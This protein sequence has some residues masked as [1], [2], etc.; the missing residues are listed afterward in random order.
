M[1]RNYS[2]LFRL[3]GVLLA[4]GSLAAVRS[5]PP[6]PVPGSF[7]LT[8]VPDT[9]IYAWKFPATYNAQMQ[10]I[11]T[12]AKKYNITYALHLGDI[13]EH[14]TP[15]EWEVA[16]NAHQLLAGKVPYTLLPGNHDMGEQGKT[17]DRRTLLSD[18]FPVAEFRT[19]PSYGGVYDREPESL[20]NSFHLFSAGGRKWLVL[21]LEFAPRDDVLRWA[22]DVVAAHPDRTVIMTTHAY[23]QTN[24]KRYNRIETAERHFDRYSSHLEGGV[25][26]GEDMWQKLLKRHPNVALVISGHVGIT[27]RLTSIGDAGNEVHQMVVDYQSQPE[28]GGGFLRLLTFLPDGETVRVRDYSPLSDETVTDPERTYDFKIPVSK[29][30]TA[31]RN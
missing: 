21:A 31:Q 9:Q 18:Y 23:L 17:T 4:L 29:Q 10:W 27:G 16:R 15:I 1:I 3:T 2:L 26:D 25:N 6:E 28:G 24:N 11:A 8:V 5:Q 7:T 30:P 20:N 14:N 22:N 19:W 12:N 13:T